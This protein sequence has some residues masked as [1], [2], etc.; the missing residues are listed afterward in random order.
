VWTAPGRAPPDSWWTPFLY[1]VFN[2]LGTLQS[3]YKI[4]NFIGV[5][6]A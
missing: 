5:N 3:E 1:N 2:C 4:V 6:S